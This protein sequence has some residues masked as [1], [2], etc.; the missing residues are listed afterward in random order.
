MS[1]RNYQCVKCAETVKNP[2]SVQFPHVISKFSPK[3]ITVCQQHNVIVT[4]HK[5]LSCEDRYYDAQDAPN[6]WCVLC[7][8]NIDADM[9]DP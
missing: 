6:Q 1:H 3:S 9:V 5:C 4:H 2:P 8:N 7:I